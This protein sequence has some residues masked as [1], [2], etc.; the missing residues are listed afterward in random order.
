MW[1]KRTMVILIVNPDFRLLR[2][3]ITQRLGELPSLQPKEVRCAYAFIARSA[4][5]LCISSA[6]GQA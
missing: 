4:H 3:A 5:F 2:E 6:P 1:Q